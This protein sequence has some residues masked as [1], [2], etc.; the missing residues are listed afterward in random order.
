MSM[1]LSK[2]YLIELADLLS[3]RITCTA[4][5]ASLSVPINKTSNIPERC[6]ACNNNVLFQYNGT[7]HKLILHILDELTTLRENKSPYS[8]IAFEVDQIDP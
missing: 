6:Q 5:K 3:L 7:E 8:H 4:C 1:T 2:K